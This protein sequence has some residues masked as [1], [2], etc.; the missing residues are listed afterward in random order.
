MDLNFVQYQASDGNDPS[1]QCFILPLPV[2]LDREAVIQKAGF[3]PSHNARVGLL[4]ME[5]NGHQRRCIIVAPDI[6]FIR[7]SRY[8]VSYKPV[9]SA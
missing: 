9:A 2:G 4:H 7:G 6:N 1:P 5:W 3:E 8:A